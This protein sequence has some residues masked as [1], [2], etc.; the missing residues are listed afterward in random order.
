MTRHEIIKDW[1]VFCG[2]VLGAFHGTRDMRHDYA[3]L[4]QPSSGTWG[5]FLEDS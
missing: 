5:S 3:K 2:N 1:Q 4:E